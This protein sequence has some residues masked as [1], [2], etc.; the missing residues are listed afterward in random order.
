[1]QIPAIYENFQHILDNKGILTLSVLTD[2][3][4]V[5]TGVQQM[6]GLLIMDWYA[7]GMS[8]DMYV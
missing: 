4:R 6:H 7:T 5:R 2:T 3:A 8:H 1:M